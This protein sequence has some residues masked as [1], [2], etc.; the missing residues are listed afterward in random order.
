MPSTQHSHFLYLSTG[1]Q[2]TFPPC[3]IAQTMPLQICTYLV[4]RIAEVLNLR[5]GELP[6]SQQPL[7]RRYLIAVG[8]ANLGRR[9][10]ELA[11]VI[12]QQI[13]VSKDLNHENLDKMT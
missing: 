12:V 3:S 8:L 1:G 10:R 11:A 13:P 9:K 2:L 4:I 5:L 6:H 7:P